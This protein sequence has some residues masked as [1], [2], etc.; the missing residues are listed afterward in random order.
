MYV[1][2][3]S[4]LGQDCACEENVEHEQLAT[5]VAT[6]P[7]QLHCLR[8]RAEEPGNEALSTQCHSK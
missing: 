6:T 5:F 3:F 8:S 1:P 4:D 7:A 2:R